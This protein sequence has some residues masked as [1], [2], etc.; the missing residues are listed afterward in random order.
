MIWSDL[1]EPWQVSLE[2]A[3]KAYCAGSVPIGACITDAAGCVIARGRNCIYE[4]SA[5]GYPLYGNRMAHAEMNALLALRTWG[6]DNPMSCTL[7]TTM[8]P[9][10][11]CMGAIRMFHIGRVCYAARDGLAGSTRL[12]EA[13]PYVRLAQVVGHIEI[14]GPVR[15][16]LELVILVIQAARL[17]QNERSRWADLVEKLDPL[18][19]Q[20]I[21]LGRELF[22]SGNLDGLRDKGA[23]AQE[24]VDAVAHQL[25]ERTVDGHLRR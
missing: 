21:R 22:V 10:P 15:D 23:C 24:V 9:C 7:Y 18:R 19:A 4:S 3:W 20:G 11:M 16:D 17:L 6:G 1:S 12:V 14:V 8:E 13:E 2:E 25:H 5:D